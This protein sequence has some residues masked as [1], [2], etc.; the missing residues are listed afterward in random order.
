MSLLL[1]MLKATLPAD[2]T[3]TLY[4]QPTPQTSLSSCLLSLTRELGA[5]ARLTERGE[6][7]KGAG[8]GVRSHVSLLANQ[9]DLSVANLMYA[10]N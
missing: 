4:R 3:V 1:Q 9:T 10:I 6:E 2:L 8:G 5:R 7:G